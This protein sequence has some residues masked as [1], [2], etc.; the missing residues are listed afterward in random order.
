M[1]GMITKV[2]TATVHTHYIE[3]GGVEYE[4]TF[5]AHEYIDPKVE[6][7]DGK[8]FITYATLD[9]YWPWN[10][11]EDYE[12]IEFKEFDNAWDRDAWAEEWQAG[13]WTVFFVNHYEHSLSRYSVI[14]DMT[15]R[16]VCDNCDADFETRAAGEGG[17]CEAN[18]GNPAWEGHD[19]AAR[20]RSPH[21]RA[22]WDDRPSGVIALHPDITNPL[23]TAIDT[24]NTYTAWVNGE[25]YTLVREE[26]DAEGVHV[27]Y[28]SVGGY[29]GSE[30]A[31]AAIK[32]A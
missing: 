16:W 6:V 1:I 7:E 2:R 26:Y 28:E 14:E 31:G 9:D 18:A 11:I 23:E 4:T 22:G 10:P 13:G 30:D 8:T 29:F 19:V 25:V 21:Y 5:P 32:D 15:L 3:I 12:F 20:A 17:K 27:D 24:M